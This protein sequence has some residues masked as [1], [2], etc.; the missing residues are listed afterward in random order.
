MNPSLVPD[1]TELYI[2]I[3]ELQ[4]SDLDILGTLPGLR[5]LDLLAG[6]H[7]DLGIFERFVVGAGSFPCLIHCEFRG[8]VRPVVFEQGAMPKLRTF[9]SNSKFSVR[10]AC[11]NGVGLDLGLGILP[12][13][14]EIKV[15][16]DYKGASE[17]EAKE[18]ESALRHATK[19]HPNDPTLWV[20]GRRVHTSGVL[21]QNGYY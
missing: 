13:L 11:I 17:E 3:R 1:L 14:Q 18:L 2:A 21:L 16:L 10:E 12:S 4:S 6:H 5:S 9:R 8:F 19:I 7:K 15:W 20:N